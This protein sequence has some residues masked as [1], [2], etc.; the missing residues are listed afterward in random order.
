MSAG[1]PRIARYGP[2]EVAFVD[3]IVSFLGVYTRRRRSA[4]SS[5]GLVWEIDESTTAEAVKNLLR[6]LGMEYEPVPA[7]SFDTQE[8]IKATVSQVVAIFDEDRLDSLQLSR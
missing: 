5:V 2:V 7:L 8:A 6:D 1:K 3:S 4:R